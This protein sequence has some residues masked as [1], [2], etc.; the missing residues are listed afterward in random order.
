[1]K[2]HL[3]KPEAMY[4]HTLRNK[5]I[6]PV[7]AA[8]SPISHNNLINFVFS[9][10]TA[11]SMFPNTVL[12]LTV[13]ILCKALAKDENHYELPV[14]E[15]TQVSKTDDYFS[16]NVSQLAN[17]GNDEYYSIIGQDI[18]VGEST[19]GI[20]LKC[21]ASYPVYWTMNNTIEVNQEFR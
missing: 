11:K 13:I 7:T 9:I 3:P 15:V 12:V 1:M 18:I 19:L 2:L 6:S 5:L 4:I 17:R 8:G 21:S 20:T 10:M 14:I 16:T